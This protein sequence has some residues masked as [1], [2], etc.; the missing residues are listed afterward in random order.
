MSRPSPSAPN[1]PR[2]IEQLNSANAF[3]VAAAVEC[4]ARAAAGLDRHALRLAQS[5]AVPAFVRALQSPDEHAAKDAAAVLAGVARVAPDLVAE[6]AGS[7]LVAALTS[8][9][10]GD[11]AVNAAAAFKE[12]AHRTPMS[13][14]AEPGA[15]QALASALRSTNDMTVRNAAAAFGCCAA[16]SSSLARLVACTPGAL[17]GLCAAVT[18]DRDPSVIS[19]AM[20]A[21]TE[22]A[23]TGGG[24]AAVRIVSTPGAM[25]ALT[26]IL[27]GGELGV[28]RSAASVLADASKAG[29]EHAR[30]AATPAALTALASAASR[31]GLAVNC[32]GALSCFTAASPQ[33][34]LRVAD[35]PG[36]E[37]ALLAAL[38][39]REMLAGA[40][41]TRA[42]SYIA[43]TDAERVGRL[44]AAAPAALPALSTLLQSTD[45]VVVQ[46]SMFLLAKL[47]HHDRT[48]VTGLPDLPGA[49]Q[50]LAA[51]LRG[52]DD[53]LAISAGVVLGAAL[54]EGCAETAERV[55]SAPGVMQAVV[56]AASHPNQSAVTNALG[57]VR[58]AAQK[59]DGGYATRLACAPGALQL[60]VRTLGSDEDLAAANAAMIL[61]F[62]CRADAGLAQRVAAV[63]GA[64]RA[65]A[66]Q[67]SRGEGDAA[68]AAASA[69]LCVATDGSSPRPEVLR[70]LAA[71][72]GVLPALVA[73]VQRGGVTGPNSLYLLSA[74]VLVEEERL[75]GLLSGAEGVIPALISAMRTSAD[76]ATALNAARALAQ[77]AATSPQDLG[78]SV[79]DAG[80]AEAVVQAMARGSDQAVSGLLQA[81]LVVDAAKVAAVLAT[82]LPPP[83]TAATIR[84]RTALA[85]APLSLGSVAVEALAHAAEVA[86]TLRARTAAL[87]A[88]ASAA[89]AEADAAQPRACAGCG[90]QGESAGAGRL[91]PCA[92]CSGKGPAGCVLYCD[93]DCQR[94]HW[95]AH[96]PYCK[97]AAAAAAAAER[98]AP[99]GGAA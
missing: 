67:L 9:R 2:L 36:V 58:I 55:L 23:D 64:L 42:F 12:L 99:G 52:A 41:A 43:N 95:P 4:A 18:S 5:G 20:S 57:I 98:S 85:S 21:L 13:V 3:T 34:A 65:L 15:L 31:D 94:A 78:R 40:N 48:L 47:A 49:L 86:A 56:A 77:I 30:A 63:P 33:L 80:A 24:D 38:T 44:V 60:L 83:Y 28:A 72:E 81:L 70:R 74:V 1:I 92:G 84:A 27:L 37:V 11:V 62:A 59:F 7:A 93:A 82:A 32:I 87:E 61:A 50:A 79:L 54:V 6:A 25:D 26:R 66:G 45:T 16:A 96:K 71:E 8:W 53:R 88:L 10:D 17:A 39:G 73:A 68:A 90:L 75:V 69:L 14:A 76:E 29:P 51:A 22:I 46:E 19:I 97:R 35:A 89:A 91:W